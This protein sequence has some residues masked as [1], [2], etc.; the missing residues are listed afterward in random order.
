MIFRLTTDFR[1]FQFWFKTYSCV[2]ESYD[3][4]KYNAQT[5]ISAF[6]LPFH[7]W[8]LLSPPASIASSSP[9]RPL[10]SREA[11]D[12]PKQL[13]P[14]SPFRSTPSCEPSLYSTRTK[15]TW[16]VAVS[17][18]G[19]NQYSAAWFRRIASF[20]TRKCSGSCSFECCYCLGRCCCPC[21]QIYFRFYFY[22][23]KS[24]IWNF[25]F[26]YHDLVCRCCS[27]LDFV[28]L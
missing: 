8:F 2:P 4:P 18:P 11:T 9:H 28:L 17:C 15:K 24:R 26:S 7:L 12:P 14:S 25:Y 23:W 13:N 22:F 5:I 20:P 10:F 19:H 16:T 3:Q 1:F 6:T 27:W 21:L